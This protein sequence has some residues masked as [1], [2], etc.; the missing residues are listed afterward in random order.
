[1]YD[2]HHYFHGK[3]VLFFLQLHAFR[4]ILICMIHFLE[5]VVFVLPYV[6]LK[7]S[8]KERKREEKD[9]V[10]YNPSY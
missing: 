7:R 4:G 6:C 3:Y 10:V 9:V 8:R 1:M 2:V 5:F